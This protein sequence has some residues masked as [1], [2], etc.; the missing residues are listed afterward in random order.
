MAINVNGVYKTVLSILNKEQRGY[1]TPDEFNKI[2]KQVQLSLLDQAIVK[3]NKD[4][5]SESFSMNAEGYGDMVQGTQEKIDVFYKEN[6]VSLDSTTGA[7]TLPTDIYKIVEVKT[8]N[9]NIEQV[10]KNRW[11]YVNSTPMLTPTSDFP[12]YY[13]TSTQLNVLPITTS[14]PTVTYIK[15]PK[16]PRWGYTVNST[17]GTNVYDDRLY[18]DG[19]LITNLTL[20]LPSGNVTASGNGT[21][22]ALATD[23]SGSG[24]G[25]TVKVTSSSANINSATVVAAG[26]GYAIGD[27]ITVTK[28]R[29]DA[30]SSIGTTGGNLVITLVASNIYNH[31]TY[32]SCD[33]ELH[34][35]EEPNLILG[36]LSYAGV[37]IKDP[38]ITQLTTQIAQ[39][40][41]IVKQQ[42]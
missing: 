41:E 19:G 20:T 31:N 38:A 14:N 27:T 29:M 9:T 11:S 2:S 6:T 16:D 4:I 32:G 42:Q 3:Y 18:V 21:T 40:N 7:G 17:Y 15:V 23:T 8:S 34:K 35:T 28:A 39:A 24:T 30:D 5:N 26:S 37:T 12:I 1:I 36:I 33:F 25:A 13:K 22:A 10:D